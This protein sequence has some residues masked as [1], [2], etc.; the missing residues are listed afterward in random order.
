[1]LLAAVALSLVGAAAIAQSPIVDSAAVDSVRT[2]LVAELEHLRSHNYRE[3]SN[4][5]I[6]SVEGGTAKRFPLQLAGATMY[7]I[8]G[9]CDKN[10]DHVQ[11]SLYEP[12]GMLLVTSPEK[13]QVVVI[14]GTVTAAGTFTLDLA[15]PG[16]KERACQAGFIIARKVL[17][18]DATQAKNAPAHAAPQPDDKFVTHD[19]YDIIGSDADRIEKTDMRACA[20]AC[21]RDP[22]CVAYSYDKWNRWCFLKEVAEALRL[23]PNTISGLRASVTKPPVADLPVSIQRYRKKVFPVNGRPLQEAKSYAD[24]ESR[25]TREGS[26]VAFTF[27][28]DAKQCLTLESTGEYFANPKADSGVKRQEPR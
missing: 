3:A 7:A 8:I 15:T 6:V 26:C 10:C 28:S 1:L 20:S 14:G 17:G 19:N 4:E 12:G 13:Q 25:C 24:C 2:K 23:E 5:V 11:M 22:R 21:E 18:Q 16:C 27:F 9:V